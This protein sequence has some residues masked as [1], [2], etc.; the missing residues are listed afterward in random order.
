MLHPGCDYEVVWNGVHDRQAA[1]LHVH[2]PEAEATPREPRR[3]RSSLRAEVLAVLDA[4]WPRSF[5]HAELA[6]VMGESIETVSYA[7][8]VLELDG[9]VERIGLDESQPITRGH[10]RPIRFRR[11]RKPE[12]VYVQMG[13]F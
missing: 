8:W 11:Y 3:W 12:V 6:A 10:R 5:C 2:Q 9:E 1:R 7:R 4:T 13:L